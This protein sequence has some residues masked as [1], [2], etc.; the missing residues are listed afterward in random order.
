LPADRLALPQAKA[1][2]RPTA[3]VGAPPPTIPFAQP[4]QVPA[5][6]PAPVVALPKVTHAK[7]PPARGSTPVIDGAAGPN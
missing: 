6:P 3:L 2:R 7:R 4:A 1:E 5:V